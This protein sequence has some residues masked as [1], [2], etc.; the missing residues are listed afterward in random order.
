MDQNDRRLRVLRDRII[1]LQ[2]GFVKALKPHLFYRLP[3]PFLS[4][5]IHVREKVS[6]SEKPHLVFLH[7]LST[8]FLAFPIASAGQTSRQR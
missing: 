7:L 8:L 4:L 5:R 2:N 1:A 6:F 3:S